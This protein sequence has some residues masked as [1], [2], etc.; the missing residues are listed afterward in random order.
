MR[1]QIE[2]PL[3]ASGALLGSLTSGTLEAERIWPDELILNLV[4]N[5]R[6][7]GLAIARSIAETLGGHGR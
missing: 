4:S 1:S 6:G 5:G 7:M 3:K 2:V